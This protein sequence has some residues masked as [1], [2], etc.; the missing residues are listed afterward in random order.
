MTDCYLCD[1]RL[2]AVREDREL[3]MGRRTAVVLHEFLRCPS[4]EE[5]ILLPEQMDAVQRRASAAIR[6]EEDLLLPEE[7]R[8]IREGMGLSQESFERLLG[9]GPKTVVRWERGTVF[10]NKATD[11]LLRV[12][13]A[14]PD[15]A[16]FL[17]ERNGIVLQQAMRSASES[18][19]VSSADELHNA[20]AIFP[21]G[22]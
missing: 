18:I 17:A 19:S 22:G 14:L 6:R 10:Q 13:R 5:E 2:E 1:T 15:T 12:L 11:T 9:V 8:Q 7:I 21:A 16:L 20:R 3:R 4:C